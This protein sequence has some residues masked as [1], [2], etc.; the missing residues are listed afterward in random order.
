MV[1]KGGEVP[2]Y[3]PIE[4]LANSPIWQGEERKKE[5]KEIDLPRTRPETG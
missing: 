3:R 4:E 2:G 1:R 5:R